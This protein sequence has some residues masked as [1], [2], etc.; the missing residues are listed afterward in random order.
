MPYS[1]TLQEECSVLAACTWGRQNKLQMRH[2]LSSALPFASRWLDM[3]AEP[4]P[5]DAAMPRVQGTQ[6]GASNESS[7]RQG[8]KT[9]DC[10]KC[11]E[12]RSIIRC[13]RSTVQATRPGFA[14]SRSRCCPVRRAASIGTGASPDRSV[15][16]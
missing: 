5:G 2:P 9:K 3:P 1:Q 15:D 16:S 14:A 8:R 11:R 4:M 12:D 13:R 10:F 6:F 7:F